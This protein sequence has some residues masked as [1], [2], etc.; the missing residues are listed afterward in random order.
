MIAIRIERD[1]LNYA[2]TLGKSV[3]NVIDQEARRKAPNAKRRGQLEVAI[4]LVEWS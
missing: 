3:A 1:A 2:E 4:S